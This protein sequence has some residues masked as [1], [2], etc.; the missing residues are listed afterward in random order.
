[1]GRSFQ[2][3]WYSEFPLLEYSQIKNAAFCQFCRFFGNREAKKE[4][5]AFMETGFIYFTNALEKFS[6]HAK[7]SDH[8]AAS[9]KMLVYKRS[10]Q[11]NEGI[12]SYMVTAHKKL[13]EENRHY[14]RGIID[15][16]LTCCKQGIALRDHRETDP[17]VYNPGNFIALLHLVAEYDP[18]IKTR[19]SDG[20]LNAK[21][22]HHDIQNLLINTS[23]SIIRQQ[24][25]FMVQQC[26]YF[27]IIA[28]ESRDSSKQEQLGLPLRYVYGG[29]EKESFAGFNA[30]LGMDARSLC[31]DILTLLRGMGI[32]LSLCVAQCYD[33]ASV[34]AGSCN[35]VQKIVR[36]NCERAIYVHCYAHR[37]NLTVVDLSKAFGRL[38]DLSQ[39]SR[40]FTISLVLLLYTLYL[41]TTKK[42]TRKST[43]T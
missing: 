2:E 38:C 9:E 35:G 36:E 28:D 8:R 30:C 6:S 14:L 37:I 40:R 33:G 15:C 13:V 27:S 22:I 23:A 18:V 29:E 24:I 11:K 43:N 21:Y 42:T 1:M 17:S 20:L 31:T 34:M 12:T 3:K 39:H 7:S 16:I 5:D 4:N 19:I 25:S 10:V 41:L 26:G 32:P